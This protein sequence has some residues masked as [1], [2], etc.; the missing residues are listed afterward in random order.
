M[1]YATDHRLV[2][3]WW[4]DYDLARRPEAASAGSRPLDGADMDPDVGARA[5]A[6]HEKVRVDR[7][8]H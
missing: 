1:L 5:A 6:Q 4:H 7:A 3:P 8:L 2:R